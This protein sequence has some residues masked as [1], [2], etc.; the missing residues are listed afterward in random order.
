M[1]FNLAQDYDKPLHF[2]KKNQDTFSLTLNSSNNL[3]T[4][5]DQYGESIDSTSL[6]DMMI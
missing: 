3:G 4:T 2:Y 6:D 5:C 1:L